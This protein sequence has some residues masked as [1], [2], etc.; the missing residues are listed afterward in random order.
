MIGETIIAIIAVILFIILHGVAIYGHI[1]FIL[2]IINREMDKDGWYIYLAILFITA[3]LIGFWCLI[4][5][6]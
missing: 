6:V 5:E 4:F 3:I 2:A 1:V